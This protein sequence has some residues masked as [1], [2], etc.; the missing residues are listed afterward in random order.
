MKNIIY[1]LLV[2]FIATGCST[3]CYIPYVKS[4]YPNYSTGYEKE[5]TKKYDKFNIEY[6]R[7]LFKKRRK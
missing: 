6:R 4:N 3:S 7:Y 2:L 5:P 1:I